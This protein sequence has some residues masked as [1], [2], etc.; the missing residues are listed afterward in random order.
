M[1]DQ[2]PGQ[3]ARDQIDKQLTACSWTIQ[4]VRKVNLHVGIGVAVKE[5]LTDAGPADDVLLVD[6]KP[7]EIPLPPI[8][9]DKSLLLTGKT[10]SLFVIRLKK[11]LAK[12]C[13]RQ[14]H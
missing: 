6:G 12:V 4:S 9:K 8:K 7:C 13:C 11:P 14:N 10:N 2:N 3:L 5:Y 1:P